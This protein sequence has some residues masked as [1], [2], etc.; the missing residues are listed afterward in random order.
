M[1][2][3]HGLGDQLLIDGVN[4]SG[5][6]G[7]VQTINAPSDVFDVSAINVSAYERILG[8]LDGLMEFT[9]FFNKAAG[10]Q[11]LTL[12]AK[13][14]GANR[15]CTYLKGSAIGN[16][17]AA[18]VAKQVNYDPS[19]PADGSLSIGVQMVGAAYG[20]D[21]GTQLTAGLRTDTAATEGASHNNG[22]AS[23][24]GLSA[25][26]HVVAWSGV[27]MTVSIQSSSDNGGGDAFANI[28][29]GVFTQST[30]IGAERIVT[31][32]TQAVEQ[33]LRVT[34]ITSGGIT[35]VT[36]FVAVC[37]SPVA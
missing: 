33:Y 12:R 26:L 9:S 29:G 8:K 34:T 13:A 15:V 16:W 30:A 4:L 31:S 14:A 7:S 27:D 2:K 21:H 10:A 20:L 5:D 25:Y 17:A 11:H 28:T 1:A 32:L 3:S 36:F 22:A 37:R 19:R 18:I 24:R 6:V 35:S 23:S